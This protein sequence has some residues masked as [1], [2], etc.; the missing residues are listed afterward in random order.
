MTEAD[1]L[2]TQEVLDSLSDS[3]HRITLLAAHDSMMTAFLMAL[4]IYKQQWPLY[5]SMVLW[6]GFKTWD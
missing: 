3:G 1:H 6:L 4:A 5:C 2:R